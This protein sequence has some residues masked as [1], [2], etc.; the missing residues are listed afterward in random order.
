MI[1]Q[2]IV[3]AKLDKSNNQHY[4]TQIVSSRIKALCSYS[5]RFQKGVFLTDDAQHMNQHYI[6]RRRHAQTHI[7]N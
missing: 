4:A 3:Q 6:C 5:I 7:Y 1:C 2:L